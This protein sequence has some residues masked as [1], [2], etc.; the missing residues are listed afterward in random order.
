MLEIVHKE[1]LP[2]EREL[3]IMLYKTVEL[4]ETILKHAWGMTIS[5]HGTA[6]IVQQKSKHDGPEGREA[7]QPIE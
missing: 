3:C 5:M 4:G 2:G 6:V 1:S 7:S